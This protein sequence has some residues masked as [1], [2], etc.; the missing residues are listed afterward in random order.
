MPR[1][2]FCLLILACAGCGGSYN[3]GKIEG[4]WLF[5]PADGGDGS[6]LVF[7]DEGRVLLVRSGAA[8]AVEWRYK[9]LAGDAADFYALPPAGGLFAAVG[10]P[11]R[12]SVRITATPGEPYERREM[13]LTDPAG[14]ERRLTRLP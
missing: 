6:A 3:K 7:D 5:V 1:S 10:G 2:A 4:R 14:R 13:V 12:V 8:T 11:I 9:L